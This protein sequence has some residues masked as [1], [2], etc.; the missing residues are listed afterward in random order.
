MEELLEDPWDQTCIFISCSFDREGLSRTSLAICEDGGMIAIE[1]LIDEGGQIESI[2]QLVLGGA[3]HEDF[4]ESEDFL[5]FLGELQ[6]GLFCK[7]PN[8]LGVGVN[9]ETLLFFLVGG[10]LRVKHRPDPHI[11]RNVCH[12]TLFYMQLIYNV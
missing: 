11:D 9:P 4:V 2:E 5:P 7:V 3:G 1:Y 10:Y 6:T 12:L 8:G